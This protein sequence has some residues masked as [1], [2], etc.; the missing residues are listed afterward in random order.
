MESSL[1]NKK[2]RI[3]IDYEFTIYDENLTEEEVYN[4][5]ENEPITEVLSL[6]NGHRS[7]WKNYRSNS[8]VEIDNI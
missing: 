4:L 3:S 1:H 2:V 6:L 7:S 5:L 8:T